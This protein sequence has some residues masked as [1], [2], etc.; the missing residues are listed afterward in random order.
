MTRTM[1]RDAVAGSADDVYRYT[2]WRAPGFAPVIDACGMAGGRHA[3]DP[4]GGDAVF[5]NIPWATLG[6]L[7]SEVLKKGEPG[8]LWVAGAT[9]EVAWGIRYNHGGGYQYRLCPANEPL[10]EACFQKTPLPFSGHPIIR[11][12]NGTE[13]QIKGTF[14]SEGTSPNGSTWAMNPIPRIDFDSK[15]SGQPKGFTGCEMPAKGMKCR[16]FDPPCQEDPNNPW[17]DTDA[18]PTSHRNVDVQGRCSGDLTSAAIVDKVVLPKD[19]PAGDYVVGFRWDCEETAQIW[20]NC[21]DITI[22]L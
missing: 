3:S 9:V 2:P 4:S 19:L 6:D 5:T 1:N 8:A 14:V 13:L 10:T 20:S 7:G 15:S 11:W 18:G 17:W 21:A 16:Q 22:T 12:D